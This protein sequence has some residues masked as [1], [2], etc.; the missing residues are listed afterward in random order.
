LEAEEFHSRVAKLLY[1][2][3]RVRPDI[4]TAVIFLSTRVKCA[5]TDDNVKL[6]RVLG[7]LNSTCEMGLVLEGHKALSVIAYVDASYGVHA[8]L[9]SHTGG[10]ITLG[11][12]AVWSK[13]TRQKLNTKSSTE[14]ELVAAADVCSQVIWTRDFL[15]EQGYKVGPASLMQDNTSTIH[16]I[17]NGSSNAEKTRHIS[18]RF[19]W[20]KD[21]IESNEI[22]IAYCP[23][24]D[25]VADVLT[26]PLQ[27]DTFRQLRRRLL[28]WEY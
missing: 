9:K 2:A 25:M 17:S 12:G 26:K 18:I 14:A 16:L 13:S 10:I 11:D 5:T 3:K 19:F 4:L 1:L 8:D 27:G 23:T 15:L 6:N 7:Y 21:R 28:N 20:M 22:E 24:A